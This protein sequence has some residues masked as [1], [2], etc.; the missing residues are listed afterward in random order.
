MP[1]CAL[2]WSMQRSA[3]SAHQRRSKVTPTNNR[4][5]GKAPA[6]NPIGRELCDLLLRPRQQ[7][8]EELGPALAV[9]DSV[10][11]VGAE[12]ALEGDHRFLLVRHVIAEPLEREEESGV[13]PIR[14][15][16]VAGRARQSEPA[17]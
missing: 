4:Y 16:E 11:Q 3:S 17:L 5:E 12:A 6:F 1:N 13:G 10:D 15:D 8:S 7:Q 2:C 14:V 9:D